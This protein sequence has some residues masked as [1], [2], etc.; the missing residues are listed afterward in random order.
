MSIEVR[1][2]FEKEHRWL[3][4]YEHDQTG[5]NILGETI[6]LG[7]FVMCEEGVHLEN[8]NDITV[9]LATPWKLQGQQVFDG[10][11]IRSYHYRDEQGIVHWNYDRVLWND[12]KGQWWITSHPTDNTCSEAISMPLYEFLANPSDKYPDHLIGNIHE[13][14]DILEV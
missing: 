6:L 12:A 8:L 13:N 10:D 14:L 4:G 11:I 3:C 1:A 5:C 9:E 2:W 7:G